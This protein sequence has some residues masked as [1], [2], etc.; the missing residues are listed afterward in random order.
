[1]KSSKKWAASIAIITNQKVNL[2]KLPTLLLENSE[3]KMIEPKT[4]KISAIN[5]EFDLTVNS[6]EL[7]QNIEEYTDLKIVA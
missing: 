4:I 6:N 1:M 7:L 2:K 3:K 5:S